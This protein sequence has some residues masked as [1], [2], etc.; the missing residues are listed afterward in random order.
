MPGYPY[1]SA[2]GSILAKRRA[3]T[4]GRILRYTKHVPGPWTRQI[5]MTGQRKTRRNGSC[6]WFK[7]PRGCNSGTVPLSLPL[8]LSVQTVVFFLK[9]ALFA[10][11]LSTLVEI[12]FCRA[13]GAGPSSLTTSPVARIWCF[14]HHNSVSISGWEPK[15]CSKRSQAQTTQDQE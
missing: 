3:G 6:K 7:L 12:L 13:E 15:P 1:A 9:N 14:H 5:K 8:C 10:S 4:H 2:V 11:L